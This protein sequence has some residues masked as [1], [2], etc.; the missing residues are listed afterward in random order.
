[1]IDGNPERESLAVPIS[2]LKTQLADLRKLINDVGRLHREFRR[3]P[4]LLTDMQKFTT[5]SG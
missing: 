1:M 3:A 5:N 4:P 2:E